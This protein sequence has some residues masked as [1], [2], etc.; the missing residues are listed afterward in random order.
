M[1]IVQRIPQ[2][3]TALTT[4]GLARLSMTLSMLLN[5]GVDA[6]RSIK[7]AFWQQA[8]TTLSAAC[9]GLLSKSRRHDFGDAFDAAKV[10]PQE[11]H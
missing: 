5:A 1:P 7:Q 9:S 4:L 6:R 11:F 10:L 8:I 2:L 3:G